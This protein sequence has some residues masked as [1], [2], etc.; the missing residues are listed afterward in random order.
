MT[1]CEF[2][3]CVLLGS[4]AMGFSRQEYWNGLPFPSP[5]DL[6]DPQIEPRSPILQADS[7]PVKPPESLLMVLIAYIITS[8]SFL[9]KSHILAGYMHALNKNSFTSPTLP[10]CGHT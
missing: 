5:G 3:R 6:P 4:L 8:P 2:L 10:R 1:K 7:L 9:R